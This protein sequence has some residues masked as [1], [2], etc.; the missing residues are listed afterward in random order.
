MNDNNDKKRKRKDTGNASS[1][2]ALLQPP[3]KA[4]KSQ[5]QQVVHSPSPLSLLMSQA[6]VAPQLPNQLASTIGPSRQIPIKGGQAFSNAIKQLGLANGGDQAVRAEFNLDLDVTRNVSNPRSQ[7][8]LVGGTFSV[9]EHPTTG[10]VQG[11]LKTHAKSSYVGDGGDEKHVLPKHLSL[12][13]ATLESRAIKH[14]QNDDYDIAAKSTEITPP[15][16]KQT[17]DV[18]TPLGMIAMGSY[19]EDVTAKRSIGLEHVGSAMRASVMAVKWNL[20]EGVADAGNDFADKTLAAFP[21]LG[22]SSTSVG[23]M[24]KSGI[25]ELREEFK[26][27]TKFSKVDQLGSIHAAHQ[28]AFSAAEKRFDTKI[29]AIYG[30]W[31]AD[32]SLSDPVALREAAGG[33]LGE[34]GGQ[35][36]TIFA[37]SGSG[38]QKR[39]ENASANFKQLKQDY[40]QR[41]MNRHG[42]E[43]DIP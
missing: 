22:N 39:A 8:F 30:A 33:W 6:V 4:Q 25:S 11:N 3:N 21:Q 34:N 5:P 19:L 17:F 9:M 18:S 20:K 2:T 29:K 13:R 28:D 1:S 15:G 37:D 27:E 41:K 12:P 32:N 43:I 10:L 35:F 7:S 40:L 24:V 42:I 14:L 16:R 31:T 26:S 36:S 38:D 23:R